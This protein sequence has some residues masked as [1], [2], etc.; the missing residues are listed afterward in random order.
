MIIDSVLQLNQVRFPNYIPSSR[1]EL[2]KNGDVT[3]EP[4]SSWRKTDLPTMISKRGGVQRKGVEHLALNH[5][6]SY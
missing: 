3:A 2:R 6:A 4:T 1:L 5:H